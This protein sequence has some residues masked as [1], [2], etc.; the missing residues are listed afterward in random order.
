MKSLDNILGDVIALH[1]SADAALAAVAY[2]FVESIGLSE[3][4]TLPPRFT[5]HPF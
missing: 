2:T 3:G 5:L 1:S 4:I